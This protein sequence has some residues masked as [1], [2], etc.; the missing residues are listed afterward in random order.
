MNTI[1]KQ[2]LDEMKERIETSVK[3]EMQKIIDER[4]A[5][6]LDVLESQGIISKADA[7]AY[8]KE[9]GLKLKPV[10]RSRPAISDSC[11]SGG[12]RGSSC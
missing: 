3:S 10:Q 12:A 7:D 6:N 5:N 11:G 4:L 1:A 8:R 9:N 2:F